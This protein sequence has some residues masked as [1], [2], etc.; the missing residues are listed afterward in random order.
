VKALSGLRTDAGTK[1]GSHEA[2]RPSGTLAGHPR[3]RREA[4][5]PRPLRIA[6]S[7][8]A[9]TIGDLIHDAVA[10]LVQTGRQAAV[11]ATTLL[12]VDGPLWCTVD[13]A[14]MEEA[15]VQLLRNAYD[16][17]SDG[18]EVTLLA[19]AGPQAG[20]VSLV[21]GTEGLSS[22]PPAGLRAALSDV[23]AIIEAHGG[24]LA[25]APGVGGRGTQVTVTLPGAY[26][27]RRGTPAGSRPGLAT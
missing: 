21:L 7:H 11:A 5:A 20:Q 2:M 25:V 12:E 23:R 4:A 26:G 24:I 14:A 6:H 9:T 18:G 16:A 10:R 17:R 3:H 13:L 27:K 19:H 1:R 22:A 15:F 8:E